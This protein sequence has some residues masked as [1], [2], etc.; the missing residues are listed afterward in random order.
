MT[1]SQAKE[2]F[3]K[4]AATGRFS[5]AYMIESEDTASDLPGCLN[6]RV[7]MAA[8]IVIRVKPFLL[9]IIRTCAQ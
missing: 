1:I 3:K 2:Y 8:D 7:A 6:V 9:E 5:H 4:A